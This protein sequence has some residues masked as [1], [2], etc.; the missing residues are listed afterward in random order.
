MYNSVKHATLK[1][2][3]MPFPK[4]YLNCISNF[5]LIVHY[6]MYLILYQELKRLRGFV[7]KYYKFKTFVYNHELEERR[8]LVILYK[9]KPLFIIMDWKRG[10]ASTYY[11]S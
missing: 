6:Y 9:L 5:A 4:E 3:M 11:I 2:C 8:S 1:Q 10:E 7:S